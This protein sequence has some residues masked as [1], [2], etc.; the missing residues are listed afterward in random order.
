MKFGNFNF[1][2]RKKGS[3]GI[4]DEVLI[5]STT[6]EQ[7]AEMKKRLADRTH[8]L[9]AAQTKINDLNSLDDEEEGN[10]SEPVGPHPPLEELTVDK[11]GDDD[12][13][14]FEMD[15]PAGDGSPIQVVDMT[16]QPET[17][18]KVETVNLES[19]KEDEEE[20]DEA[21]PAES[22]DKAAT[23]ENS[24]DSI[25]NLFS[26]DEE[27]ENPLANLISFLPDVTVQELV[28]DIEE[29]QGI[30]KEWQQS[31]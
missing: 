14:D 2:L 8:D 12:D 11:L 4:D 5:E 31:S 28:D 3:D 7:I 25:N 19:L 9:E 23:D 21:A 17:E 29:I 15:T 6:A 26:E 22:D 10:E 13:D 16:P 27:E 24:D 1:S 18:V 20:T 30:I